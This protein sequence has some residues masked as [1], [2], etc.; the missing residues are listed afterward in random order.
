MTDTIVYCDAHG[1]KLFSGKQN[2]RDLSKWTLKETLHAYVSPDRIPGAS[3]FHIDY[4]DLPDRYFISSSNEPPFGS[5]RMF[6]FAAYSATQYFILE[7]HIYHEAFDSD[8]GYGYSYL[9]VPGT[10][11]N[12]SGDCVYYCCI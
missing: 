5:R 4:C 10:S 2:A 12:V 8:G 7:S 1:V 6:R 11:L 9:I 3:D